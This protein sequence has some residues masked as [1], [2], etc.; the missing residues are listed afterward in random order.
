MRLPLTGLWKCQRGVAAIELALILPILVTLAFG[1]FSVG[2]MLFVQN[3]II[4]AA[5]ETARTI[6]VGDAEV[7][8]AA[9]IAHNHLVN[10]A[11]L[12]FSVTGSQP[13]GADVM[14]NITVPMSEA[15]IVDVL[16]I[17]S[18]GTL[19]TQVTMR[20]EGS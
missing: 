9:T 19:Q 4:H 17:F 15:A 12:N 1:T 2:S 16:G 14:V 3:N 11:G 8:E 7:A 10:W 18:S 5:R 20:R 6:A 13:T